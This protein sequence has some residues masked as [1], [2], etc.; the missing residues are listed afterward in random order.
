ME[1]QQVHREG[2]ALP[3][4]PASELVSTTLPEVASRKRQPFLMHKMVRSICP[5]CILSLDG[6]L[7]AAHGAEI[8]VLTRLTGSEWASPSPL[9]LTHLKEYHFR[10]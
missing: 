7:A 10:K 1:P 8:V 9:L 3:V 6:V 5:G 2:W 4:E